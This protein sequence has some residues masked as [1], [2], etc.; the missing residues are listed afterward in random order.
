LNYMANDGGTTPAAPALSDPRYRGLKP[1][2]PGHDPRRGMGALSPQERDFKRFLAEK[3]IPKAS[4]AVEALYTEG[5]KWL[6]KG[7]EG[8]LLAWFKVCGLIQKPTDAAAIAE[9]ARAFLGEMIAEAQARRA[10]DAEAHPPDQL[11]A[12]GTDE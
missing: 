7:K 12:L 4:K 3:Q 10:A 6:K 2:R 5:M 11:T 1:F 9:M 8:P